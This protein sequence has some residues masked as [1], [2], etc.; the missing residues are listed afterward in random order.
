MRLLGQL[1]P[2]TRLSLFVLRRP[3][4]PA[5]AG[6]AG[7]AG[8][9]ARARAEHLGRRL[10]RPGRD[11][12]HGMGV[13]ST[14][15]DLLKL[16]GYGLASGS[17]KLG[18]RRRTGA[19]PGTGRAEHRRHRRRLA[20]DPSEDGRKADLRSL[21]L[22]RLNL[23]NLNLSGAD[24]RGVDRWRQ[25]RTD[26]PPRGE[27]D[28][29]ARARDVAQGCQPQWGPAGRHEAPGPTWRRRLSAKPSPTC[30][31]GRPNTALAR[32]ARAGAARC[33]CGRPR[34]PAHGPGS[35]FLHAHH[36]RHLHQALV[37]LIPISEYAKECGQ[38]H[39]R[40]EW[41]KSG[42]VGAAGW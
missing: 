41:G 34:P 36:F 3:L 7:L 8:E 6:E 1:D 24:L 30:G 21:N 27:P 31:W 32:K 40:P 12:H 16:L 9:S 14:M 10:T 20:N 33:C 4:P 29:C 26:R 17:L 37:T 28:C 22:E 23:S 19:V 13:E 2:R 35:Q 5:E 38:R 25:P 18:D 15:R 11:R 42:S 39:L